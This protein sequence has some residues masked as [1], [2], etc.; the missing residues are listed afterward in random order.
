MNRAPILVQ[1]F[2][3]TSVATA[4]GRQRVIA[5]VR[6]AR[7]DGY[8][9]TVVASAMGRRG[10]PYATDTLLDL[11][12]AE[13]PG[14]DPRDYD[15]MFTC[16][17]A[18]SVALLAHAMKGAGVPAVGL[19]SAQARIYTDGRH[20]EAEVEGIDT[21]R[22]RAIM[23]DGLV[24]IVT[25]GQGVARGTL[26]YTTLGRGG[27]DTSGVALGVALHAERVEIFSDV[28]GVATADPR[29]VPGAR[30][31]PVV[32]YAA[33]HEMAR[34]G[35]KILHPRALVA[36]WRGRT[37]VAVR[38]TFDSTPG[39][40][41]ADIPDEQP[42][43]GLALLR[44]MR[45][46]ALAPG[47]VDAAC[48]DEWERRH[49]VMGIG[50][51][52]TGQLLLAAGSDKLEAFCRL[53]AEV[54]ARPAL[55]PS[56]CCWLSVIGDAS[57]VQAATPR[58][59]GLLRGQGIDVQGHEVTERRATFVIPDDAAEPAARALHADAFGQS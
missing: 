1:K 46:V 59:L 12:H 34:F 20:V 52:S 19:T 6:R 22:L 51:A 48:R 29:V 47:T 21:R 44:G 36:G 38:P 31:L 37:P 49:L 26:D 4:E 45:T 28:P 25:G 50:D 15:L 5:H 24:P 53:L 11:L 42:I 27:S 17:E 35:A 54:E 7:D 58:A 39:T 9:V 56:P 40:I 3:G 32:S 2:G 57:A 33:M 8:R 13:G 14:V 41:V 43:V 30:V 18:I 16:G 55:N 10:D 23:D